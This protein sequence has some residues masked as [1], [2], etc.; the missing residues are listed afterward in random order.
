ME[1]VALLLISILRLHIAPLL[2]YLDDIAGLFALK[3][4]F[5]SFVLLGCIQD[6]RLHW[7]VHAP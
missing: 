2:K 3:C 6:L 1:E 7:L 4:A 5:V